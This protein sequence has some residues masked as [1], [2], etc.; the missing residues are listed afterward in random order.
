MT[1]CLTT[2]SGIHVMRKLILAMTVVFAGTFVIGAGA[3]TVPEYKLALQNHQFEPATL[4]VPADTKFKV[5]VINKNPVPAEFESAEFNREKIVLPG[6]T[7]TVFIGP[8]KAG[9][10]HFFDDFHQE[11]KGVLVVE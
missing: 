3:Q 8:L 6:R 11:T 10:Y 1:T 7:V 9:Q 2:A 4:K 5:R